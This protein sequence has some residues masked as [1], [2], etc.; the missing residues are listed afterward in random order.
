MSGAKL[1]EPDAEPV[2]RTQH[3]SH[4]IGEGKLFYFRVVQ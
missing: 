4:Q 2:E 1:I 3:M